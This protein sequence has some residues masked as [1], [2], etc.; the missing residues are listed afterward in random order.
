MKYTIITL[1]C[2]LTLSVGA[3]SVTP[4]TGNATNTDNTY[5]VL[6]YKFYSVTDAIGN[7]T[8]TVVPKNY[9]TE[10]S[11]PILVDSI[12]VKVSNI[13]NS[14]YGD[15]LC[16]RIINSSAGTKVKFI[17]GTFE[18]GSGTSVITLTA[19]KRANIKFVFDGTKWVEVSRLVQ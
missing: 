6:N 9:H 10:V 14:Y 3:Q 18:V 15:E 4:R 2:A 12:S 7:D 8:T 13:S 11:I 5:R 17:G 19:S 16:V 1:L